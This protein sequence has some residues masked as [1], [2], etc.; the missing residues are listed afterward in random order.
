MAFCLPRW[1]EGGGEVTNQKNAFRAW[2]FCFEPGAVSFSLCERL[3]LQHLGQKLQNKASSLFFDQGP[4]LPTVY[5]GRQNVIHM[6]KMGLPLH[7]C[8][9]QAIK[10][11]T[12]GRPW[13]KASGY[14]TILYRQLS[15]LGCF[16]PSDFIIVHI[17]THTKDASYFHNNYDKV[18]LINTME[19]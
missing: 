10:N 1:T 16:M 17:Y 4:L 18:A 12:V 19:C 15:A 6:I 14:Y 7:F 13:N 3:K 2:V 11:W 5:L 8:I 9:L